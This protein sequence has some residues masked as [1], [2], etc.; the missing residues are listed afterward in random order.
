[1]DSCP[2]LNS[3]LYTIL[4]LFLFL[5]FVFDFVL[6]FVFDFVSVFFF[7][8]TQGACVGG[9]LGLILPMWMVIGSYSVVGPPSNMPF[10]TDNCTVAN[11]TT[12]MTT[13][14]TMTTTESLPPE[15]M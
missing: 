3:V 11:V 14:V 8:F 15:E 1:M 12:A 4:F 13:L 7:F 9:V 2:F 6:V 5:I 10:P